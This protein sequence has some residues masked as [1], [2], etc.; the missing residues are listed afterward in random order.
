MVACWWS[1][2]LGKWARISLWGP[3]L[4]S[5]LHRVLGS[6]YPQQ[7]S[8]L[9]ALVY[10]TGPAFQWSLVYGIGPA[11]HGLWFT[12]VALPFSGRCFSGFC[13]T[14]PPSS[15]TSPALTERGCSLS[16]SWRHCKAQVG[17]LFYW[18]YWCFYGQ[19]RQE[20][21]VAVSDM[22]A[23][24]S[25]QYCSQLLSSPRLTPT[26]KSLTVLWE[27][28]FSLWIAC[29]QDTSWARIEEPLGSA[30]KAGDDK[31]M[32]NGK[33]LEG[34]PRRRVPSNCWRTV[35]NDR[36][37]EWGASSELGVRPVCQFL[38]FMWLLEFF[39]F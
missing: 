9:W 11:L 36:I 10:S 8:I 29:G 15:P 27:S 13:R 28:G 6:G 12:V 22:C 30:R 5:F 2:L 4:Q 35:N 34:V 18:C 24:W 17:Q 21:D 19:G 33:E 26:S 7:F 32:E 39:L 37:T 3:S 16:F 38:L 20:V 14:V 25:V 23:G 31:T 1:F